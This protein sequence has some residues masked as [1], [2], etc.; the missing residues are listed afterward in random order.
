MPGRAVGLI[1]RHGRTVLV[2]GLIAGALLPGLALAMRPWIG[3]MV[4]SLLFL[5]AL[6]VGPRQAVGAVGDIGRAAALTLAL[7]VAMPLAAIGTALLLGVAAAPIATFIVLMLAAPPIS[8]SPHLAVMCGDDPGPVLRQLV[9]GTLFLPATV[10][11][12]FWLT[13]VL[14]DPAEV[15]RVA[16]GLTALIAVAGG[17]AFLLRSTV[18]RT[19]SPTALQAI[20]AAS[21]LTM[22]I[23][24]IGLMS[25]V[26]PAMRESPSSFLLTL[27]LVCALNFVIQVAAA[28][29]S[30]HWGGRVAATG[31]V[32]GNR[33][34]ALF[35]SVLPQAAIDPLLLFIGCYQI[36]MYITPA[37]LGRFYRWA[38]RNAEGE[39][40]GGGISNR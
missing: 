17:G 27:A 5:A 33:N 31:I 9:V 21:A 26:G 2:L 6:R 4:A 32:S 13:P 3:W 35:L 25:A 24:V 18:L 14:G 20:D 39:P 7:Q 23:V 10:L 37:M 34:I 38:G 16:G 15:L 11:P 36:P 40:R 8:G 30:R 28:L 19:P 22:A 29:S 1:A 12:V